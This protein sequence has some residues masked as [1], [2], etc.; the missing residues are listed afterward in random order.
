MGSSTTKIENEITNLR[1]EVALLRSV[2]ISFLGVDREGRY[3][4]GFV[5]SILKTAKE[6]PEHTF[7]N[8]SD[9]LKQLN[10]V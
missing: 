10:S 1:R 7:L 2:I 4:P 9:F 5:K 3:R 8:S 6:K